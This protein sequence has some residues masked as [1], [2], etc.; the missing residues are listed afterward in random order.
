MSCV[1]PTISRLSFGFFDTL[2]G[3]KK[4]RKKKPEEED[5]A[6]QEI[7]STCAAQLEDNDMNQTTLA[8]RFVQH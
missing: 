5:A 8:C 4:E 2:V 3:R 7:Y 6:G 1:H